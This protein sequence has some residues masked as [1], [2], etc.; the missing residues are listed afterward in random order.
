MLFSLTEWKTSR[1][2]LGV[3]VVM[4]FPLVCK[5]YGWQDHIMNFTLFK[6]SPGRIQYNTRYKT[7]YQWN[8][9]LKTVKSSKFLYLN[10]TAESISHFWIL[11]GSVNKAIIMKEFVTQNLLLSSSFFRFFTRNKCRHGAFETNSI[12]TLSC[13]K[14]KCI[15]NMLMFISYVLNSL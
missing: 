7:R 11:C 6:N 3:T 12:L 1:V 8:M 15:H 4:W 14:L 10:K 2:A 13:L 9:I 5:D